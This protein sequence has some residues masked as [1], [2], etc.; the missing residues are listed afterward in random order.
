MSAFEGTTLVGSANATGSVPVGRSFPEGTIS[1]GGAT[2]NSVVLSASN[3]PFFAVDNIRVSTTP[4][5]TSLVLL[6][7]GLLVLGAVMGKPKRCN[8]NPT[9]PKR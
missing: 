4:E 9:H 8:R 1:L 7:S 5:P 3:A 2:F 6:G